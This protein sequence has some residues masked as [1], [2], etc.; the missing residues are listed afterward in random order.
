MMKKEGEEKMRRK[1]GQVIY[2][3]QLQDM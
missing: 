2:L 3:T 1:R